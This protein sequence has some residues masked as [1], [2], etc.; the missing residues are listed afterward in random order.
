MSMSMSFT[1]TIC[2]LCVLP[3][4]G[5]NIIPGLDVHLGTGSDK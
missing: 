2:G 1:I 3:G 5:G 4:T